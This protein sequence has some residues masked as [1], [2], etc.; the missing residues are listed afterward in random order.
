MCDVT[1][2]A[3]LVPQLSRNSAAGHGMNQPLHFCTCTLH[4]DPQLQRVPMHAHTVDMQ[5]ANEPGMHALV[6]AQSACRL[7]TCSRMP[8]AS[9]F[10]RQCI[11]LG[12]D[13]MPSLFVHEQ[14]V[15][16][17]EIQPKDAKLR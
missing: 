10:C 3:E 5:A 15:P 16:L 6:Q 14:L 13:K 1:N 7:C 9:A 4:A 2:L 17:P 8:A 12:A 11:Y